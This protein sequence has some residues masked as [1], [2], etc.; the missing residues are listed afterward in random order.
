[1]AGQTY[2]IKLYGH[3][4]PNADRFVTQLAAALG[5]SPD[6]ARDLLMR[7]PVIVREGM[8]RSK[9]QAFHETLNLIRALAI[10]EAEP[11]ITPAIGPAGAA[12]DEEK[13]PG[14]TEPLSKRISG[15]Q[16][17]M[18]SGLA[19]LIALIG[20]MAIIS[21]FK[22]MKQGKPPPY[23]RRPARLTD[24]PAP[25][26]YGYEGFSLRDLDSMWGQLKDENKQLAQEL[27]HAHNKSVELANTYG[28][29][30]EKVDEAYRRVVEL[31]LRIDRN[32]R[33]KR[34]L[35]RR[36]R[37]LEYFGLDKEPAQLN[38]R[39]VIGAPNMDQI[40]PPGR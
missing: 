4:N 28:I 14:K 22:A 29:P 38:P 5:V 9:A 30:E 15:F 40:P 21:P 32:D 10:L 16:L 23:E 17:I 33:E 36:I 6:E 34:V 8:E 31:R 7:V 18:I 12:E 35:M 1:M 39:G 2:R 20:V 11:Q 26:T 37:A 25:S 27:T 19:T 13:P 3:V 24:A